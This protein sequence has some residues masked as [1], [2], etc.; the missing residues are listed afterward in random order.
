MKHRHRDMVK[1]KIIEH[2]YIYIY[3]YILKCNNIFCNM[4]NIYKNS[5]TKDKFM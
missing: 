3:I 2:N 1:L 4:K 5:L